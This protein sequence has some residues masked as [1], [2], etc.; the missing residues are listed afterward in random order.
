MIQRESNFNPRAVSPV[1][2]R[3]LGQ[4]MPATAKSLGVK[5]SF[6][7]E[8]NLKGAATYLTRMLNKFGKAELALAAY[9]AGPGAVQKYRGI[10]PYRETR[11]YVSDIFSPFNAAQKA[12]TYRSND[13]PHSL[14]FH[15]PKGTSSL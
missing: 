1:G 11:Q 9:N 5:N 4:L 7:P 2:A 3:G 10:P 15:F 8:E 13:T 12:L 6:E 14:H